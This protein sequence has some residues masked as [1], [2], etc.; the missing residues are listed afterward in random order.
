MDDMRIGAAFRAVRLRR[1]WRQQDV[2]DRANVSRALISLIERGHIGTLTLRTLHRVAAALEIRIDVVARWRGAALDRLVNARHA[3]LHES[4]TA[5]LATIPGW[6]V[7]PEV[8]FAIFGE[9][10]VIDI[11]AL[12]EASGS[13]LVIELKT[14]IVDVNDLIGGVDR[15][16]RLAARIAH[17]R[18]WQAR[19][20]ST[21]LIVTR[22]KTNERRI[23]AHRAMLRSAFPTHGTTM[24]AWV[25]NP[26]R[27]VHALSMW[28]HANPRS[29]SR[30][31]GQR[32][33][34]PGAGHGLKAAVPR[35]ARV[36]SRSS[37]IAR[38]VDCSR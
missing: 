16:R 3:A 24:R 35:S 8:S 31:R 12:H 4:V 6:Q 13:L 17:D 2:A 26:D 22:D 15:K 28:T 7:A 34:V 21:W 9:R 19:S 5:W 23:E 27:A 36:V 18:G 14:D 29:G 37:G 32:M 33:G 10:G 38:E 11:F 30:G 1:G 25:R 20:V